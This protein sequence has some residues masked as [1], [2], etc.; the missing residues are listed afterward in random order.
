MLVGAF[1]IEIGRP[2]QVLAH[3]QHKGMRG[4][5]IE[6]HVENVAHL[7]PLGC[8]LDKA[9]QEARC[10][11]VREPGVGAL[12][13]ERIEDALLQ[14]LRA[15]EFRVRDHIA[16]FPVH[17]HGDRHAPGALARDHPVG[18]LLDH[19][20]KAVPALRR[21]EAR[22]VEGRE[23]RIAQSGV[24][25]RFRRVRLVHRNEPLRRVAIDDGR[26]RPP[27]MRV[28]VLVPRVHR[29][30]RASLLQGRD[31]SRISVARVVKLAEMAL[32]VDDALRL[33]AA[34][35]R[36]SF[37]EIPIRPDCIRHIGVD[38]QLAEIA[39]LGRPDL[40]VVR[41]VSGRGMYEARARVFGNVFAFEQ[42]D[43]EIVPAR[44]K[45]M[46]RDQARRIDILQKL[47]SL[48]ARRLE[49]LL[50]QGFRQD[51]A[52]PVLVQLS[53]GASVTL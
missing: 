24:L 16:R 10:R 17:E 3:F 42:R 33:F 28:I 14:I 32:V 8:I 18:P 43:L 49:K 51:E 4:A 41:A 48:N 35:Q 29:R 52:F 6:P 7:L 37:A 11:A 5:G 25:G 22:F 44:V 36:H 20:A 39:R 1:E 40:E 2:F 34:E 15:F 30:E 45:R 53:A 9:I 23:R 31:D 38:A 19:A 50:S 46:R 13:L 12:G 26:F 21:H 47:P 27:G